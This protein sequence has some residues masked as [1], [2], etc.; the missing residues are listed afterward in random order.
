VTRASDTRSPFSLRSEEEGAGSETMSTSGPAVA[1]RSDARPATIASRNWAESQACI[2][3]MSR[4]RSSSRRPAA[5]DPEL[6]ASD[7]KSRR[8]LL[9]AALD[10]FAEIGFEGSSI[11]KIADRAGVGFQLVAYYF[12]SK[13]QLWLAT[14]QSAYDEAVQ[15]FTKER[16]KVE[17]PLEQMR[18]TIRYV[19]GYS[20]TRPQLRKIL[21]Q[22][23]LAGSKR[24]TNVLR[25]MVLKFYK[26][27]TL[28]MY[29]EMVDQG[30]IQTYT[31]R[32]VAM[33]TNSITLSN[34]ASI[35]QVE[36]F[37]DVEP[38]S[39]EWVDKETDLLV[40]LLTMNTVDG[41]P[42]IARRALTAK[43]GALEADNRRLKELVGQLTL[44]KSQLLER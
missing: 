30:L 43:I 21:V 40:R 12:G 20:R 13:E 24:Y 36:F 29:Q 27:V 23:C 32:E 19:I 18:E 37:L 38:H 2:T 34:V 17:D 1:E 4:T 39:D 3:Y 28:P 25:P 31:A 6:A 33:L 22:E 44:D 9:R 35:F 5:V 14:V 41:K 8:R 11:R 7:E 15:S 16:P 10:S 26:T 42:S